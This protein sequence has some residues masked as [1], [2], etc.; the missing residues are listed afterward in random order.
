MPPTGDASA[1]RSGPAALVVMGVSGSGKSTLA[2]ALASST[3]ALLIEGDAHHPP[4]NI[5][6]MSAGIPLNDED[7]W[8]WLDDIGRR[9]REEIDGG[10]NVIAACSALKKVYR[11]RLRQAVGSSLAFV[12]LRVDEPEL[13][14]R[15][16]TRD[17]HF[18]PAKLLASQL[19]TLEPPL[20][21]PDVIEIDGSLSTAEQIRR[22]GA[23]NT[24]HA[25]P[26]SD[27]D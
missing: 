14:N 19:S 25:G 27:R 3:G 15:M 5:A 11:D 23:W 12:F 4:A 9:M 18:M 24:S 21:E 22:L 17:G 2:E 26:A 16:T 10:R 7:R 13:R 20:G 8:P 1:A 6:K